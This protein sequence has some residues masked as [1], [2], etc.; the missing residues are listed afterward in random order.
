LLLSGKFESPTD[1]L[2]SLKNVLCL[3]ASMLGMTDQPWSASY[4]FPTAERSN[5]ERPCSNKLSN[6][7][8][9]TSF[10]SYRREETSL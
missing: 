2:R 10:L 4:F 5:Q 7:L 6:P 3:A 1:S 8:T 9:A